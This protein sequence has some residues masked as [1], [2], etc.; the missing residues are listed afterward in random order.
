MSAF[1]TTWAPVLLD[2]TL[3]ST[4]LLL[5]ALLL[6]LAWRRRSAA[7]RHAV[8]T[9]TLLALPVL[10]ILYGSWPRA[11]LAPDVAVPSE[12]V[13]DGG[14]SGPVAQGAR[15]RP[16]PGTD[17]ATASSLTDLVE[18]P[19]G[20]QESTGGS[21]LPVACLLVWAAGVMV[22]ALRLLS[23]ACRVRRLVLS[24][25]RYSGALKSELPRLARRAGC[26]RPV[27]VL[28]TRD[29][30]APAVIGWIRPV[31]VLPATIVARV[32][33][34]VL[35]TLVLHEFVH[36]AR[37]DPV[38]NAFSLLLRTLLWHNPLSWIAHRALSRDREIATDG[39]VVRAARGLRADYAHGL[40]EV[41]KTR[42]QGMVP[43]IAAG[44]GPSAH[45]RLELIVEGDSNAWAPGGR[46]A[47]I[48][49]TVFAVLMLPIALSAGVF[50]QGTPVS[51]AFSEAP[52]EK[53]G[54]ERRRA[55][56]PVDLGLNAL[57]KMQRSTGSWK[58]ED[59]G[60]VASS[61]L[62]ILAFL[63]AGN[64]HRSGPH[65]DVVRKGLK[66]LKTL[67]D[68]N[69]HVGREKAPPALHDR[70][71]AAITMAEAYG[72]TRS[73]IWKDTAQRLAAGVVASQSENGGWAAYQ[74]AKPD[75][76]TTSWA[77]MAIKSAM[78]GGLFGDQGA[79]AEKAM[80]RG[81]AFLIGLTDA[82][83][84]RVGFTV[85][86]TLSV[87]P[88][89]TVDKFP[90]HLT[91]E[92]TAAAMMA[93]IFAGEDPKTPQL[94]QCTSLL[95]GKLPRSDGQTANQ[96]YWYFGSIA[97][98]QVGG[99][100]WISWNKAMK[101]EI[102]GSQTAEGEGSGTWKHRGP[103][104]SASGNVAATALGTMCLEVYYRYARVFG[105]K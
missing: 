105:T 44:R 45:E 38:V 78:V 1:G 67:V 29:V 83:T 79:P 41:L 17:T 51:D 30:A 102:A 23:G 3:Q 99:R 82:N 89:G 48:A 14:I 100:P 68:E 81:R 94:T 25:D 104:T 76:L 57:V 7:M 90:P 5:A 32:P 2:L 18:L 56:N 61:S 70:M 16:A 73:G 40:L 15:A 50:A 53:P 69:G 98:F 93:R 8:W 80:Q 34:S 52:Q 60:D 95:R 46:R 85:A 65:K 54:T 71:L 101:S 31:V 33:A 49:A 4:I 12:F 62:A 64:T 72:M 36:I 10:A 9:G 6:T 26:A 22:L 19:A 92:V 58:A 91:E 24:A 47:T 97:M 27:P 75:A 11:G 21:E 86:G 77:M 87:R 96:L 42:S 43:S 20:V 28:V 35:E 63:G 37:K 88:A 74:G 55:Q 59:G 39:R 66:W 103:W 13:T 84:G